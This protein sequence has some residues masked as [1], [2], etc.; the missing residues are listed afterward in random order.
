MARSE[1]TFVR[2]VAVHRKDTHAWRNHRQIRNFLSYSTGGGTL[3]F[4]GTSTCLLTSTQ[5]STYPSL[6]ADGYSTIGGDGGSVNVQ[7]RILL[8]T[9]NGIRTAKM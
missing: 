6:S 3:D 5:D 8:Q 2:A 7:L 1:T 9:L 4:L